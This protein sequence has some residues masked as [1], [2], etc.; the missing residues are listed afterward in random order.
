MA[1]VAPIYL[2]GLA[3][4]WA[5]NAYGIWALSIFQNCVY[6]TVPSDYIV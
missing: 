4:F 6:V 5:L 3:V 1:R 2:G